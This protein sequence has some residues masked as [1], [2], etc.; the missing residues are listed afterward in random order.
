MSL[1]SWYKVSNLKASIVFWVTLSLQSIGFNDKDILSFDNK[2]NFLFSSFTLL[3][4]CENFAFSL[5][6]SS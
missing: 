3:K 6:L 1:C 2:L 4:N 5:K